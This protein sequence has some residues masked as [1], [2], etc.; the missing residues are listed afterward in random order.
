M[1]CWPYDEMGM[2]DEEREEEERM[3]EKNS[4]GQCQNSLPLCYDTTSIACRS[5]I[6]VSRSRERKNKEWMRFKPDRHTFYDSTGFE[7]R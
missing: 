3:K 6:G 1:R 7:V 2:E 4:V 5:L